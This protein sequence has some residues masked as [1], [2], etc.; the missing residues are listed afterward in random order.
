MKI[1]RLDPPMGFPSDGFWFQDPEVNII[2]LRIAGKSSPDTTYPKGHVGSLKIIRRKMPSMSGLQP[3][4]T[5][6]SSITS[7]MSE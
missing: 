6:L 1:T 7:C 4:Q 5:I 2:E 3:C